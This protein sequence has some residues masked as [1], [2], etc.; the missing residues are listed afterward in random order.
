M[1]YPPPL[2]IA[3]LE[4]APCWIQVTRTFA[5]RAPSLSTMVPLMLPDCAGASKSGACWAWR[6]AGMRKIA[7]GGSHSAA[8]AGNSNLPVQPPG[9]QL[10]LEPFNAS[11]RYLS[12]GIPAGSLPGRIPFVRNKCSRS[13]PEPENPFSLFENYRYSLVYDARF[14]DH[15]RYWTPMIEKFEAD[16]KE[17]KE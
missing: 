8:Q 4:V 5:M 16:W 7:A 12:F 10:L 14:P 6:R 3:S 13:A 2:V 17:S 1:K 9:R 15:V 11:P